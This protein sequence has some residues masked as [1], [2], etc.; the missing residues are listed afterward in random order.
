MVD[1]DDMARPKQTI[2]Y[3]TLPPGSVATFIS[4]VVQNRPQPYYVVEA[5]AG[6]ITIISLVG[7]FGSRRKARRSL[8]Q[9]FAV[10]GLRSW[11]LWFNRKVGSWFYELAAI[12]IV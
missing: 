10:N 12:P 7:T 9:T 11:V 5:S 2:V 1:G 8:A 4:T 3:R 6:A